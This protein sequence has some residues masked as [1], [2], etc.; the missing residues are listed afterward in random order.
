MVR[1]SGPNESKVVRVWYDNLWYECD[2]VELVVVS[3]ENRDAL[4]HTMLATVT[5]Q[6]FTLSLGLC[7]S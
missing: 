3:A 1:V 2:S 5:L 6:T 7:A 4:R